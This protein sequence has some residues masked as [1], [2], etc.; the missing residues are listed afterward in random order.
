M[1]S[2][3]NK[4]EGNSAAEFPAFQL[5]GLRGLVR[6]HTGPRTLDKELV[7]ALKR[8][9]EGSGKGESYGLGND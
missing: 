1:G 4:N 8:F 9:G 3:Y 7:V 6:T 5:A 2:S